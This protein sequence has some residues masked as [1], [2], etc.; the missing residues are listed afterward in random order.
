MPQHATSPGRNVI[1]RRHP[2]GTPVAAIF[3]ETRGA[4]L[5]GSRPGEVVMRDHHLSG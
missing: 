3:C 4:A 1:L 5:A 2:V